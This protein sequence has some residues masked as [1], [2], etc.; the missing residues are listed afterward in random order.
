MLAQDIHLIVSSPQPE[1]SSQG[2]LNN[3]LSYMTIGPIQPLQGQ[4]QPHVSSSASLWQDSI[5]NTTQR[6]GNPPS[7]LDFPPVN[8]GYKTQDT[9]YR[10][11]RTLDRNSTGLDRSGYLRCLS[12]ITRSLAPPQTG[13]GFG[14]GIQVSC[15]RLGSCHQDTRHTLHCRHLTNNTPSLSADPYGLASCTPAR[16]LRLWHHYRRPRSRK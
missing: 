3:R 7:H 10:N 11:S 2:S 12:A 16:L 5:E 9:E 4:E 6:Q 15:V 13:I 14:I 8:T 1:Q